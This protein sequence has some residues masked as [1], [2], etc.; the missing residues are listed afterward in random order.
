M[1]IAIPSSSNNM[2]QDSHSDSELQK[3]YILKNITVVGM[4]KNEKNLH[5]M[6]P[7]ILLNVATMSFQ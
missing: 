7:N 5:I 4:L 3:M 1:I 6:C 2:K